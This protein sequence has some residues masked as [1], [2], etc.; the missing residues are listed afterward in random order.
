[1]ASPN[2]IPRDMGTAL[3]EMGI[4]PERSVDNEIWALCPDHE[5]RTGKPDRHA[6]WSVNT[7][8]GYHFCFSCG[9]TG[10]FLNLVMDM[11]FHTDQWAAL[12]WIGKH[13]IKL[14]DP[15]NMTP[16][17]GV[18]EEDDVVDP[19]VE[20]ITESSLALFFR[21][22]SAQ[23]ELRHITSEAAENYEILWNVDTLTSREGYVYPPGW[24]FPVRM[25]DGHLIGWQYK[26]KR[27]FLNYPKGI[28][29]GECLFLPL[30]ITPGAPLTIVESPLDAA[31]MDSAGVKNVGAT[32][33]SEVTVAQLKLCLSI[34]TD[35]VL[36]LDND[37]AGW[38]AMQSIAYGELDWRGKRKKDGWHK[39]FSDM[40]FYDYPSGVKDPG[41]MDDEQV[42]EGITASQSV[43]ALSLGPVRAIRKSAPVRRGIRV[44]D[45]LNKPKRR[46][47]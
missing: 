45:T 33:G 2:R 47:R 23:M 10:T 13:G 5:N 4:K 27:T 21:P 39:R 7:E 17:F 31:R 1:M 11:L 29:K 9:Y 15:D 24:I 28:D 3:T 18:R 43:E 38:H 37:A 20:V 46:V 42:V 34:S 32:Y 36:A 6:S 12:N 26:N 14:L 41:D 16:Y 30:D 35:L 19:E 8:T 44:Q 22:P 25:P 40:R